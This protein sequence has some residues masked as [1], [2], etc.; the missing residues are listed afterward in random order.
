MERINALG[1][2]QRRIIVVALLTLAM[3]VIAAPAKAAISYGEMVRYPLVF[4]VDGDHYFSDTFGAYR[5]H[6]KGHRGQDIMAAKGTRV[7]AAASGTVRYVNWTKRSHL[8]P[9]RCCS[10]VVRHDDGW[11]TRYLHLKNDTPGT[12]DGKGW[13]IADGI[14][15]GAKVEVGRL[16]GWVGDS[17]NA[18][19]TP[20][21]LHFELIDPDGVHA[22]SFESLLLAGGNPPPPS[23]GFYDDD[24]LFSGFRVLRRGVAG[25]ATSRLQEVLDQLGYIVGPID[26]IFGPL[27]DAGVKAFQADMSLTVDGLVGSITRAALVE[28]VEVPAAV[29]GL[30]STGSEV[31]VVQEAL[32]DLGFDPGPI[33][34]RFGPMTLSAVLAFQRALGLQIDGLVG[35]QTYT[36]LGHR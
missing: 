1:A 20:P 26:G 13:G 14:V 5:S 33:D 8:N 12:D 25:D 16:L 24:V 11:E 2:G 30:G 32:A 18:E 21:H 35:P 23:V 31:D 3:G 6:G 27:T 15:P 22:N 4:P 7:V 28:S 29:L 19:S 36:R 10:V 17:G 9:D 34:G